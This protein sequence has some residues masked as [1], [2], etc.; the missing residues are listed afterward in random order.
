[1]GIFCSRLNTPRGFPE[2][3]RV[4]IHDYLNKGCRGVVLNYTIDGQDPWDAM[5][6]G[7]WD[8]D[9]IVQKCEGCRVEIE[10][11]EWYFIGNT[12]DFLRGTDSEY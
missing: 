7:T 4:R 3:L 6:C 5:L 2:D 11:V 9:I 10:D 8:L 12:C 1:M